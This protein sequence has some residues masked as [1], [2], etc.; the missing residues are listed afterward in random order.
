VPFFQW[1]RERLPL[2]LRARKRVRRSDVAA[3]ELAE[4]EMRKPSRKTRAARK[5]QPSLSAFSFQQRITAPIGKRQPSA[6]SD[7]LSAIS[8]QLAAEEL[9]RA[10]FFVLR[11]V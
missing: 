8:F 6:I 2:Q 5:R 4:L 3:K 11:L 7:Q 9:C 10:V 1:Y